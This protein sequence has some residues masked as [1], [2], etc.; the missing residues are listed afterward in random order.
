MNNY[1]SQHTRVLLH[2]TTPVVTAPR[3]AKLQHAGTR[4]RPLRTRN[5]YYIKATI[6]NCDNKA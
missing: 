2:A 5:S 1:S 3:R 6:E 4:E